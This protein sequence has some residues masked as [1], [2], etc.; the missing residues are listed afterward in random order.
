MRW[1]LSAY[2]KF[3]MA[4]NL[5]VS[6]KNKL[7]CN[8]SNAASK[9]NIIQNISEIYTNYEVTEVWG[10]NKTKTEVK[11]TKISTTE[12][13]YSVIEIEMQNI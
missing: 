7:I 4:S 13:K 8:L 6:F 5:Y 12:S 10:I 11:L 1:F 9:E 3:I 2:E